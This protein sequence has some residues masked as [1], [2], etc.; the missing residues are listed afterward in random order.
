[1]KL[2]KYANELHYNLMMLPCLIFQVLFSIVP[3]VGI[4]LAF[5]VY[6]PRKGFFGSKW[7]GLDNFRYMLQLPDIQQIFYNTIFLAVLKIAFRIVFALAFALLLNEARKK[8]FKGIVQ[9]IVYIPHFIS[10]VLLAAI[11][12]DMFSLSGVVNGLIRAL[13]REPVLFMMSNQWFPAILVGTEVLKEFGYSAIIFLAALTAISP[14]LYEAADIDGCGRTKKL[15]HITLPGITTTIVLVLTLALGDV[16]NA[17]FDQVFNMYNPLVYKS[18]DIIDTYVYRIGLQN[19]QFGLAT[20]VG[21]LKSAVS[22]V[23]IVVSYKLAERFA[24]YRIF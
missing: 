18:A 23:L 15:L 24:N 9:T 19:S 10:W 14:E 7:I 17:N 8:Y 2:K 13:G 20:A 4:I 6:N 12:N 11:F 16:M 3:M 1:M 5:Q 21:L 22:F